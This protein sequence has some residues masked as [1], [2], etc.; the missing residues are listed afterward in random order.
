MKTLALLGAAMLG[1]TAVLSEKSATCSAGNDSVPIVAS[2]SSKSEQAYA[3]DQGRLVV[4]GAGNATMTNE[5]PC[6]GSADGDW[7]LKPLGEPGELDV[8]GRKFSIK[9]TYR[10]PPVFKPGLRFFGNGAAGMVSF[11]SDEWKNLAEELA[12][13]LSRMCGAEIPCV[14]NTQTGDGPIIAVGSPIDGLQQGES[15]ICVTG[16]R[17]DVTGRGAGVSFAVTYLLEALGCR[18]LWPGESG[19][20]IPK[21]AEIVLPD[22]DWR[23]APEFKHR[24]MRDYGALDGWSEKSAA[25]IADYWNIDAAKFF[26]ILQ[27]KRFDRKGNR[28]FFRWHGVND[29]HDLPGHW[30]AVHNFR[31]FW[32]KYGKEHPD[33]FALQ[34]NGSRHQDLGTLSDRNTLCLANEG[35]REQIARDAIAAFRRNHDDLHVYTLGL[36]DGGYM[37]QC[38]CQKCRALDPVNA[39][40]EKFRAER[41]K[42]FEAD[43]VCLSD[44][45]LDF[46][47]DIAERVTKEIPNAKFG[48]SIYSMYAQPS[49]K[50]RPHPALVLWSV[51]GS[52]VTEEGR[53]AARKSLAFWSQYGNLCFWR[54]NTCM[55]FAVN[56]PQNYARFIFE[57]L[58]LFKLNH[59]IGT[60]FDCVNHQFAT[61]GLIWYAVA[62]AHR[63]PDHIGYDDLVDDYCRAGFGSAAKTVRAYF[64]ALEQMA[65]E[66]TKCGKGL[67]SYI[68]AFNPVLLE[69]LLA[70]AEHAAGGDEDVR[71]RL[72]FLRMGLKTGFLEKKLGF[73][74][75]SKNKSAILGLQERLRAA[76]RECAYAEPFAVNPLF[77]SG[78]FQSYQM[79]N[80]RF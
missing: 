2:E 1:C 47:N 48:Y 8:S 68:K 58:E 26:S 62:K 22:I 45:L 13:H 80:P 40:P 19:K 64:D 32:Q 3:D 39:L 54:P 78:Y 31:D 73:A 6:A 61:K 79:R 46:S 72:A 33:W 75:A 4:I 35:L 66:A 55:N 44:R 34:P 38:M 41:P 14:S 77:V 56:A 15:V 76:M 50:V 16:N 21:R 20:I 74:W 25:K 18:Y 30:S 29:K 70:K 23:Y 11:V 9:P 42:R 7:G 60:D 67:E 24:V 37:A 49:V 59:V 51:A 52:L 57:D 63:N 12:W 17:M 65:D 27:E 71:G 53:A 10:R 43:Y 28:D 5:A 69:G 36:P